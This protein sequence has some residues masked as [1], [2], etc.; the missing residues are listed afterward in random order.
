DGAYLFQLVE[1]LEEVTYLD[2]AR[3]MA[4]DHP[5]TLEVWPNEDFAGPKTAGPRVLAI[6]KSGKIF[7]V[8]AIDQ[9]DKDVTDKVLKIDRT[10]PDE[11]RLHSLAGYA[12]MHHLTL[13]F[14]PEVAGREGLYLFL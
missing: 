5:K 2:A 4:V 6:E 8:R 14:P 12:E 3:L 9:K 7:P 13:E 10:Y 1:N 11:F